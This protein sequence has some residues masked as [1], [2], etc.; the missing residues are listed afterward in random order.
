MLQELDY[1]DIDKIIIDSRETYISIG[2][3]YS[4]IDKI[5]YKEVE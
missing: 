1:I 2:E 5:N 3:I 4:I